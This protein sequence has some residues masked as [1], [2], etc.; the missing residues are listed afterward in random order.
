MTSNNQIYVV[1][2]GEFYD[3]DYD[4]LFKTALKHTTKT[5][6]QNRQKK[7]KLLSRNIKTPFKMPTPKQAGK[8]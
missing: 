6:N 3:Y 8:K 1:C 4:T 7:R 5:H 2:D